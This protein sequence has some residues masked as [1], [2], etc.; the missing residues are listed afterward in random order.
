MPMVPNFIQ[1]EKDLI[2]HILQSSMK[3]SCSSSFTFLIKFQAQHVCYLLLNVFLFNSLWH[4]SH[5]NS[6]KELLFFIP[7]LN[8]MSAIIATLVLS[9]ITISWDSDTVSRGAAGLETLLGLPSS[10]SLAIAVVF[11]PDSLLSR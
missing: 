9:K 5:H 10:F 4:Y 3:P 2:F 11:L 8:F 6:I 7:S 1:D